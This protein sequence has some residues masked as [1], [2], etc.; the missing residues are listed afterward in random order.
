MN[1]FRINNGTGWGAATL[2]KWGGS[3]WASLGGIPPVVPALTR[4]QVATR[5]KLCTQRYITPTGV[6]QRT[7]RTSHTATTTATAPVLLYGNVY[8][9]VQGNNPITVAASFDVAGV[10]YPVT[11]GG[12]TSAVI[13]PG[14]YATSDPVTGLTIPAGTFH[15]RTCMTVA[16]AGYSIP[17]A[18]A[19]TLRAAAG[20]WTAT[21]NLTTAGAGTPADS[22][23]PIRPLGIMAEHSGVAVGFVGDSIAVG[24]SDNYWGATSGAFLERSHVAAGVPFRNYSRGAEHFG[25]VAPPFAIRRDWRYANFTGL[26]HVITEYGA[27]QMGTAGGPRAS[28]IGFWT[29]AAGLGVKVWQ[30]TTTPNTT[31]TDGWTTLAGQAPVASSVNIPLWN[32]WLRDGAPMLNGAAVETGSNATG[33]IRAGHANHPLAGYLEIADTVESSR[34]SGKW[35]VDGGSIAPD[36]LH[37]NPAGHALMAAPVQAW[38]GTL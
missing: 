21:G 33:T 30:T 15:V 16:A 6:T 3:A 10:L 20:E 24:Y 38:L 27:N 2:K 22:T 28:A 9:E 25:T 32:D 31:S 35:R 5:A 29:Y 14:E 13:Q 4:R 11:F 17:T 12:A 7:D 23:L 37:P 8:T 1:T 19:D 26:T 18:E 36:G 34:N